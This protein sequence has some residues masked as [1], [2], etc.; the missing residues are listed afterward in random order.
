MTSKKTLAVLLAAILLFS[1]SGC[2]NKNSN[3]TDKNSEQ[4]NMS[5]SNVI[6]TEYTYA[7]TVSINPEIELYI[8][9]SD[10]IVGVKYLNDDAKLA[11]GD[12]SLVGTNLD[13]GLNSI[14]DS[15]IEKDY[16]KQDSPVS[17]ELSDVKAGK[18]I[19]ANDKLVEAKTMV[20]D[21]I[22]EKEEFDWKATVEISIAKEI[23][24]TTESQPTESPTTTKAPETQP[25]K[26]CDACHGTGNDCKECN[27]AG[28]VNCKRC[29]NGF[30]TCGNCNGS[31]KQRCN[32]CKG[33]GKQGDFG[34]T[35]CYCGG[36]GKQK[37]EQCG[38]AGGKSDCSWCH[39]ALKHICP[40]C[41]GKRVC[42][43]CNGTGKQ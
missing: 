15:A 26:T 1:F 8:D 19:V 7:I 38:G 11:Y 33:S 5:V 43:K 42:S 29:N 12:L 4:A 6:P 25:I 28:I 27:G 10:C 13:K 20:S 21:H 31:G 36:S 39:G 35:C 2:A 17:I 30:E 14:L 34:E 37:C 3:E 24:E 18:S 22:A 23:S 40:D 16:L 41:E 32:G 9:D